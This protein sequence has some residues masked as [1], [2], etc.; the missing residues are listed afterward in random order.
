[1][2]GAV[3]YEEPV[4]V[5]CPA[6]SGSAVDPT[7]LSA[8]GSLAATGAVGLPQLL[9]AGVALLAIGGALLGVTAASRRN[10][11][12]HTGKEVART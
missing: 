6:G 3:L 10:R 12:L 5:L 1:M 4:E 7:G 11:H 9:V 2:D 8:S